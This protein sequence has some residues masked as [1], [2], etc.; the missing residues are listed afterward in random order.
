MFC[1][2]ITSFR[3]I[4]RKFPLLLLFVGLSAFAQNHSGLIPTDPKLYQALPTGVYSLWNTGKL[5]DKIDLSSSTLVSL[6]QGQ[7]G[8]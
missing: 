6:S 7:K 8:S 3:S 5:P 2:R 1:W 4:L